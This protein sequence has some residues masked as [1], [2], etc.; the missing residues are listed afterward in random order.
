[1]A[2]GT[3]IRTHCRRRRGRCV[4]A[5][6]PEFALERVAQRVRDGGHNIP[7]DVVI[8]RYRKGVENLRDLYLPLANVAAVYDNSDNGPKLIAERLS[9]GELV[10][11]DRHLWAAI[12]RAG[13]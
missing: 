1:M 13:S 2:P 4:R 12:E 7:K 8:R 6:P 11:H 10:V 3:A 9:G 5:T